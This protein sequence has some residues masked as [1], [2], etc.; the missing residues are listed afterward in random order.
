MK[1]SGLVDFYSH[2]VSHRRCA[3]LT[4][5]ELH[6]ELTASKR[7]LERELDSPCPYLCWPYG[8]FS[9]SAVQSAREAGYRGLFTTVDG[10][11]APASDPLRISRIEVQDSVE[12]LRSRLAAG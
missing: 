8:S 2:T 12:W 3:D 7:L 5:E 11:C 9:E 4:P 10:F 6:V 1:A